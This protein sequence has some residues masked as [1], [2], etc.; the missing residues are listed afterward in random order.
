MVS[1][2]AQ[3]PKQT[4]GKYRQAWQQAVQRFQAGAFTPTLPESELQRWLEWAEWMAWQFHR[5]SSTVEGRN[6]YLSQMV[7][8]G[9]GLSEKRLRALTVIHNYG[10][11]RV[12][13]T[14]AAMRLF[15]RDFPD[16]FSWLLA[17]MDVLPLPRKGRQRV[18]H[19]PLILQSVPA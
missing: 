1:T 13:G 15:C 9:R 4:T 12:D 17:E 16:L 18:S 19:N 2:A 3:N 11:K 7:Y 8:T 14:T 10:L 6:G 5:S